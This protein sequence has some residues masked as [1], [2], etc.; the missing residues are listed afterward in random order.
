MVRIEAKQREEQEARDF[1]LTKAKLKAFEDGDT[2]AFA[3]VQETTTEQTWM[4][5]EELDAWALWDK[6]MKEQWTLSPTPW[7]E[8]PHLESGEHHYINR[9]TH[10]V[11][12]TPPSDGVYY[13]PFE[14]PAS[15]GNGGGAGAEC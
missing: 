1:E 14:P 11:R 12:T 10:E 6:W 4:H 2:T 15:S 13:K 5:K 7:Y 3:E 9:E 8:I